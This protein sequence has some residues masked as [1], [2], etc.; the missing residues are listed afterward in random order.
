VTDA[1][2]GNPGGPHPT[3]KDVA[4]LAGVAFKTVSRVLNDEPNVRPETRARVEAAIA[5][6]N[7][8][9]NVAASS[10]RRLDRRTAS[11]G[12]VVEDIANPFAS[13]LARS[14][15]DA[16][17]E[18][19]HLVLVA[20][21]DNQGQREQ[22]LVAQLLARRVDGLI[23]M[24]AIGDQ[25][26]LEGARGRGIPV[27]F[28]DRP[29]RGLAADVVLSDNV[30]GTRAAVEH[31]GRVGHRD[32]AFLGDQ[33]ELY[34]AAARLDG[35][36]AGIQALCGAAA[37]EDNVRTGLHTSVR[38][39]A[40]VAELLARLAPPTALVCG[41]NL[42]SIGALHALQRHGARAR[43]AVVGFDDVVLADLLTPGVTVVAQDAAQLGRHA[44]E[45]LF[46]RIAGA[47]AAAH[48]RLVVP[49]TLI[50]RGSGEIA[51]PPPS[52]EEVR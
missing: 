9:R 42:I 28:V 17:R 15:E 41:N 3:I 2:L 13:R 51:P 32:I 19:Q 10:I 21:S 47:D 22:E 52:P 14:V 16:A 45:L 50:P 20:S 33:V 11:I 46:E 31:L 35:Y 37:S 43:V 1:E 29:G 4:A 39:Q 25:T 24:P 34:P 12:L 44:V 30:G 8:Q 36:W 6:L 23:V 48:Q 49:V 27:V 38:A 40:A 5:R 18:R 26:Y 7:F